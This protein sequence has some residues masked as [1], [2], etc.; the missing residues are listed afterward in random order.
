ML[1]GDFPSLTLT[2]PMRTLYDILGVSPDAD[3]SKVKAAYK[4][5]SKETHPDKDGGNEEEFKA[6]IAAWE[7]LGDPK[8]RAHYDETG[9]MP[10]TD[11]PIDLG[12]AG[13][14]ITSFS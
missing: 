10:S 13:F 2:Q 7:C 8:K 5:R 6:V 4:R 12:E 11:R 3:Q 9:E 14:P 1:G